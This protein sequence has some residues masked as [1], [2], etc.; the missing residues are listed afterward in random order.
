MKEW[1]EQLSCKLSRYRLWRLGEG[2]VRGYLEHEVG[3]SAAAL[4][5]YLLFSFFPSSA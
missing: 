2:M 1:A 5:Y 3:K 4:A